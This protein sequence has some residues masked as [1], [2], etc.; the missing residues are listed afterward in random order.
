MHYG[1][2]EHTLDGR[3]VIDE[4]YHDL[5]PKYERKLHKFAK[6]KD[7]LTEKDMDFLLAFEDL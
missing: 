1:H 6:H 5:E 7:V 3:R 4:D 2:I